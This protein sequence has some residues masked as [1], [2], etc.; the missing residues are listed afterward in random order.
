MK[1]VGKFYG[2]L[3]Y[4]TTFWYILSPFGIYCG[5]F[6]LFFP[7]LVYCSETNMATQFATSSFY[8]F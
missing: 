4:F 6:G 5:Y 3:V 1:D 8:G 2:L 7:D